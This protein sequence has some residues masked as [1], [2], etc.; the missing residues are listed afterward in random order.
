V[1]V[2]L[3]VVLVCV[4]FLTDRSMI[5]IYLGNGAAGV[6]SA[7]F[8]FTSQTITLL[9]LTVSMA[10]FPIAVRALEA[11][12]VEAARQPMATN[13]ALLL[14]VGVPATVGAGILAPAITRSFFGNGY[15]ASAEIIP[16]VALSALLA[17]LK[18]CHFDAALQFARRTIQQVWIVFVAAVACVLLNLLMI[19]MWGLQGAAVASVL[20]FLLAMVMTAWWGRRH[21]PL[22]F[23]VRDAVLVVTASIVMGV[24]LYPFR[25]YTSVFALALQIVG[26]VLVYCI[27]LV[28]VNC[29]GLRGR[30]GQVIGSLI[31]RLRPQSPTSRPERETRP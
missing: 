13:A 27:V 1:P 30:V 5:A 20:T 16:L 2:S 3:T 6:Y 9:M 25:T 23:P 29:F 11:N 19:P 28:A 14:A 7:A 4:I 31:R 15:A 8:D 12:G 18:A 17:G 24:A 22:P 10:A 26:G 21:F